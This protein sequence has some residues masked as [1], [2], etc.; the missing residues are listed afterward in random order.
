MSKSSL[1]HAWVELTRGR[2]FSSLTLVPIEEGAQTVVLAQELAGLAARDPRQRV[3][4]INATGTPTMRAPANAS[5]QVLPG[6]ECFTQNDVVPVA[7]GRFG[8]LDCARLNMDENTVGMV[9]V[10]RYIDDVRA[11]KSPFTL[12]LVA[13]NSPLARPACVANARAADG[14]I[15]CVALGRTP[16]ADGRRTVELVGEENV[17]GSIAMRPRDD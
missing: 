13:S 11:G 1:Q 8:L 16:M 3:L 14:V 5:A 10:P 17:V 7:Q 9:E 15:L 2:S 12:I 4:V 6:R